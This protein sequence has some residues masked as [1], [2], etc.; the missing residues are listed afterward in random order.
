MLPRSATLYSHRHLLA[1]VVLIACVSGWRSAPV[2]VRDETLANQSMIWSWVIGIAK[3][4]LHS[5]NLSVF[6]LNIS[7]KR[8]EVLKR[9]S[10]SMAMLASIEPK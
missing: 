2:P 1:S 8:P 7:V 6:M 4:T 3:G 9:A 10:S 5:E